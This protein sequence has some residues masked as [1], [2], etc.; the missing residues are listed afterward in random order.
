V[1]VVL[2]G[3]WILVFLCLGVLENWAIRTGRVG[4]AVGRGNGGYSE[5]ER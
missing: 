5:R 1:V 4:V 3:S 2:C